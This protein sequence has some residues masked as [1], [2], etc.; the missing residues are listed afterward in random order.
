MEGDLVRRY[1]CLNPN[2]EKVRFTELE[3]HYHYHEVRKTKQ[4]PF[5]RTITIKGRGG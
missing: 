3:G 4:F 1:F 5:R 2:C